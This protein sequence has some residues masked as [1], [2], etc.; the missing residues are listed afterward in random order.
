MNLF[1]RKLQEQQKPDP[2]G[3]MEELKA[4]KFSMTAEDRERITREA[5]EQGK[6]PEEALRA[7]QEKLNQATEH[8]RAYQA[9]EA[10]KS[11]ERS[12]EQMFGG[13]QEKKEGQG[14]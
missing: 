9:K 5:R 6:D 13:K 12:A 10:V 8:L 7:H 14:Q 4:G 1:E 2:V 11:L 3:T